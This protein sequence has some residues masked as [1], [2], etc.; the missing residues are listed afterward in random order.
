MYQSITIDF[1]IHFNFIIKYNYFIKTNSAIYNMSP[2]IVIYYAPTQIRK[3]HTRIGIIIT[4]TQDMLSTY[5]IHVAPTQFSQIQ[6]FSIFW[7]VPKSLIISIR[8]FHL[9]D[10]SIQ[11][12]GEY[13]NEFQHHYLL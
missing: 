1:V 4:P 3:S 2:H 11:M 5:K 10:T 12:L 6:D 8:E 9:R 7:L 13:P